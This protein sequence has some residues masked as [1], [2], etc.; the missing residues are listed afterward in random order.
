[1][2]TLIGNEGGYK[3][4]NKKWWLILIS[5]FLLIGIGGKIYMDKR[6]KDLAELHDIQ[7]DLADYLYNNY[8]IFTV[9]KEK[10]DAINAEYN[11]GKGNLTLEEFLRKTDEL[12]EYSD[13]NKIEF[14]GFSVGPM[15]GLKVQFII[16]G[17]YPDETT[18]DTISAET[19]KWRYSFNSGNTRNNYVLESKEQSTDEKMPEEDIIYYNKGVE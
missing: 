15:K 11:K 2:I 4:E 18:L 6:E 19:G 5:I 16:N 13:I 14:T 9:D 7:T 17:V 8:R 1:M 12:K 10:F 3:V